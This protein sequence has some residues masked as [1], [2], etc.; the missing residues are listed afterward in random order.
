MK[1]SDVNW[2]L[3]NKISQELTKKKIK[4]KVN[5]RDDGIKT[6][7]L[8]RYDCKLRIFFCEDSLGVGLYLRG[9]NFD[10]EKMWVF[11]SGMS[12]IEVEKLADYNDT[13]LLYLKKMIFL[14]EN[15]TFAPE[16]HKNM[17]PRNYDDIVALI[18]K[19]HWSTVYESFMR[20]PCSY[21]RR[22]ELDKWLA[23]ASDR[24][25]MNDIL[26]L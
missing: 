25:F 7:D 26:K 22:E 4:H 24:K 10:D 21:D 9:V 5:G 3:C 17:I 8:S 14:W 20:F 23:I 11:A 15:M 2:N 19:C 1:F 13:A 16:W 18:G 12:K 6:L